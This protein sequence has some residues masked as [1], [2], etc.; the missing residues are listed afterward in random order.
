MRCTFLT[1]YEP[2]L[3]DDELS[4]C[5]FSF[6]LPVVSWRMQTT[7]SLLR[8]WLRSG[9]FRWGKTSMQRLLRISG[10]CPIGVQTLG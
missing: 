10:E 6:E 7:A 4:G 5:P 8:D 3:K 1:D 2:G 9:P